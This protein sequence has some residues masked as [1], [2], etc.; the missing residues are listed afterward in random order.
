[1]WPNFGKSPIWVHVKQLEFLC[2]TSFYYGL[3]TLFKIFQRFAYNFMYW[4]WI[5]II[6]RLIWTKEVVIYLWNILDVKCAH[7]VQNLVTFMIDLTC[8]ITWS[9]NKEFILKTSLAYNII[10]MGSYFIHGQCSL[11]IKSLA[12]MD[13]SIKISSS[14]YTKCSYF[15]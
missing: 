9:R 3:S 7:M 10:V 5:K 6:D 2:L 15:P 8:L 11:C 4:E 1:M 12:F 13:C 14:F